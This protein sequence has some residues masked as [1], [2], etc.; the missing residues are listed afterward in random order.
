MARAATTTDTFNAIA[1]PRRRQILDLLSNG[2][3]PVKDLVSATGL[4]QPQVSKHL[5]V[6]REVGAV[7]AR[8]AGRQRL[9]R[10]DPLALKP[11]HDW[12]RD[13]ARLWED[14]FTELDAVL[15]ELTAKEEDDGDGG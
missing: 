14:R 15:G 12:V 8:E 9:Y 13:Y 7:S 6:L 11:V 10:L 3:R 4:T 5:R 2:E 1:E